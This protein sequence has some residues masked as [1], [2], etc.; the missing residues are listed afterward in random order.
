MAGTAGG[1]AAALSLCGSA[2]A[3]PAAGRVPG[4]TTTSLLTSSAAL[5]A[6]AE[7]RAASSKRAVPIDLLRLACALDPVGQPPM[8]CMATAACRG[9]QPTPREAASNREVQ[10]WRW[11]GAHPPY[12]RLTQA[13]RRWSNKGQ[14][15]GVGQGAGRQVRRLQLGYQNLSP[16]NGP[17][18]PCLLPLITRLCRRAAGGTKAAHGV[19]P[20]QVRS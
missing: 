12:E 9:P 16:R 8:S 1:G 19:I 18:L 13:W 20:L 5:R 7:E 2:V 14:R 6:Q 17:R 4:T 10:F 15:R 11:R 3:L